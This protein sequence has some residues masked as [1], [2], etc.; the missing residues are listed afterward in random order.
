MLAVAE[1]HDLGRGEDQRIA[2]CEIGPAH[3]A[4][5]RLDVLG[6]WGLT[7][8]QVVGGNGDDRFFVTPSNSVHYS[9]DG[10]PHVGGDGLELIPHQASAT[11]NGSVV[12][13]VVPR[14]DQYVSLELYSANE[15][16][17]LLAEAAFVL[18]SAAFL[19]SYITIKLASWP[20]G[21]WPGF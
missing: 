5:R 12:V 2:R 20:A 9:L 21:T 4:R 7:D 16:T 1:L 19:L 13:G 6:E 15:R 3:R 14:P 8:V 11:D 17:E 18:Y 10:G